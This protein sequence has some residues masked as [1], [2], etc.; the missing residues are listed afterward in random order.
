[1]NS[2]IP[3]ISTSPSSCCYSAH[4]TVEVSWVLRRGY[5]VSG[6]D[7][8]ATIRALVA[9]DAVVTEPPAVDAGLAALE[10]GGDFADGVIAYQGETLGATVF[11]SFDRKAVARMNHGGPA[12][13]DPSELVG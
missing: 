12:A 4:S 1:M 13:A 5:G 2:V 3:P 10:A 6:D 8:A 7:V 11:A 9:V